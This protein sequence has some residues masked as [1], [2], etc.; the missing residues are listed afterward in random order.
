[1]GRKKKSIDRGHAPDV[2]YNSTT[3]SR[4]ICRMMW[5]GKK[6]IC[7][8]IMY[9]ALELLQQKSGSQ[10]SMHS[11]KRL[12]MSSRLSKSS[13]GAWVALP[14][15]YLSRFANLAAKRSQCA[16]L[17]M[18]P[19]RAP[20][21]RW[22]NASQMSFSM[23]STTPAPRSRKK[24]TCTRW[25]KPTRLL[26]ITGGNEQKPGYRAGVAGPFGQ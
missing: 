22:R 16:G 1:M 15:R 3:V 11:T 12:R 25:L 17:S 24:T 21:R 19:E 23:H 13:P 10:P 9:D 2:K 26:L 14:I 6:S 4:F 5:Q 7:T 18:P 20:A 8:S